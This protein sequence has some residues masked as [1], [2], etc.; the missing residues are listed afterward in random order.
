LLHAF[1]ACRGLCVGCG[2][3]AGVCFSKAIEIDYSQQEPEPILTGE[4]TVCGF[5]SEVCPGKEIPLRDMDKHFMGRERDFSNEPIGIFKGCYKGWAKDSYIRS[6]ASSGGMVTALMNYALENQIV[7]GIL[8]AGWDKNVLY[9]PE[10]MI[11]QN[12]KDIEMGCKWA[13]SPIPNNATLY[14]AVV[15]NKLESIGVIG[16]PCTIHAIR[17]LQMSQTPKKLSKAIVF[18][19]GLF[20]AASYYFEGIKHLIYEFTDVKSLDDIIAIDYRG[21]SGGFY[22]TTKDKRIHYVASKHDYTWHFLG[23]ASYKRDRCL[24]CIDFAAELADVSCGDIFQPVV[25]GSKRIVATVTRTDI[26]EKLVQGAAEK[27]YIEY[28]EHDPELIPAS[29]MGWESK[30]HAGLYR[31]MQRQRF[32]WPAPDYQYPLELK[33]TKRKLSFPS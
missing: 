20:C 18:T 32:S 23:P 28:S 19:I 31:L 17:K 12:V 21:G 25:P 16:L 10:P 14:E 6:S 8:T 24:M 9:R 3:C 33:M 22:V 26:G 2:A 30:K 27:G 7:D 5:C 13:A 1:P 15:K 29:G 4:C 11:A